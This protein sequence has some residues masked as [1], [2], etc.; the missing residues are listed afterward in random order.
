MAQQGRVGKQIKHAE[1]I[2]QDLKISSSLSKYPI[3]FH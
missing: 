3:L 2:Y 1:Y